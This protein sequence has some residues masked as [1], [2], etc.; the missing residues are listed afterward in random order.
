MSPE[1]VRP[2]RPAPPANAACPR[3]GQAFRCGAADVRCACF[4]VALTPA[5]RAQ[6]AK[7]YGNCLCVACLVQLQGAL[8]QD[9]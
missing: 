1:A 7:D 5:L 6:L 2:A 4:D 9:P 8:L 3:C